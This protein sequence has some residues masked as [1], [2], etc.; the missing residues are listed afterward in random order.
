MGSKGNPCPYPGLDKR[1]RDDFTLEFQA[2]KAALWVIATDLEK[3]VVNTP[4]PARSWG[5][6]ALQTAQALH[7]TEAGDGC[8]SIGRDAAPPTI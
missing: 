2:A 6:Q 4:Y 5:H 1:L 7:H 3:W 8:L